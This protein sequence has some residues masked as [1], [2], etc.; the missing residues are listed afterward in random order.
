[1]VLRKRLD[2]HPLLAAAEAEMERGRQQRRG[3]AADNN[4]GGGDVSMFFDKATAA[5]LATD[6]VSATVYCAARERQG[7]TLSLSVDDLGAM[8][9]AVQV[10][11]LRWSLL[12]AT[13][14]QLRFRCTATDRVARQVAAHVSRPLSLL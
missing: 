1:M 3:V 9:A 11:T 5:R 10:H 13:L 12:D 8:L 7:G 2:R 14:I 6:G 4:S